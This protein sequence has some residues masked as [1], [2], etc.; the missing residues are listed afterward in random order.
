MITGE[1]DTATAR[2]DASCPEIAQLSCQDRLDAACA[3]GKE[4]VQEIAQ[5]SRR[6]DF[7][8]LGFII[9][10]PPHHLIQEAT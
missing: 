5:L 2:F 10:T 8:V 6:G 1:R 4:A 3:G 7:V 9:M